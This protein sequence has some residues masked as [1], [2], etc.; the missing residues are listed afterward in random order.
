[1][2]GKMLLFLLSL[3]LQDDH[4]TVSDNDICTRE[5][6][7]VGPVQCPDPPEGC[8][9]YLDMD[10]VFACYDAYY[11]TMQAKQAMLCEWYERAWADWNETRAQIFE[12]YHNCLEG[13]GDPEQCWAIMRARH[14]ANCRA[15]NQEIDDIE[16][17]WLTSFIDAE[18]AFHICAQACCSYDC[19]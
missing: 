5:I 7:F 19:E 14:R 11:A 2:L 8:T 18:N 10:C 12:D 13:G 9:P 17:E 16:L 1:M 15:Y 3:V 4:C 6:P